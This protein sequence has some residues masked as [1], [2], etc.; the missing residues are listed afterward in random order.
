MK[1]EQS[2]RE[3]I[4]QVSYELFMEKTFEK[5]TMREIA[6]E[7]GINL[8]LVNYHFPRKQ[9][10][11]FEIFGKIIDEAQAEARELAGD[12]QI[13]AIYI[14]FYKFFPDLIN[15]KYHNMFYS[16]IS[17][18]SKDNIDIYGKFLPLN[19]GIIRFLNL[20][21]TEVELNLRNVYIFAGFK[22]L[23]RVYMTG[24]LKVG[25]KEIIDMLFENMC[26][27][28][29]IADYIIEDTIQKGAPYLSA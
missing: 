14:S 29:G 13:L 4:C 1:Q 7:L 3:K 11:L 17:R 23:I 16:L 5:T 6:E 28:L 19:N 12:N 21:L 24:D 20:P 9:E 27:L 26:R 22:E 25:E 15:K 8:S 18:V 10:I 2:T